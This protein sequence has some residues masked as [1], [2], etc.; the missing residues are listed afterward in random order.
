MSS[1]A[2]L[3]SAYTLLQKFDSDTERHFTI[4]LERDALK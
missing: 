4:I 2:V 1:L 3:H